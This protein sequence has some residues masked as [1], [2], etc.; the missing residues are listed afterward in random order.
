MEASANPTRDSEDGV[1]P[2]SCPEWGRRV[3]KNF[4]P[5]YQ[6]VIGSEL[7]REG[8]L[9]LDKVGFFAAGVVSEGG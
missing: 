7:P 1:T 5:S 9:T 4:I 2:Q 6:S 8:G 3:D